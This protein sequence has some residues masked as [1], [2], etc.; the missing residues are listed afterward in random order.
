MKKY[1]MRTSMSTFKRVSYV[2]PSIWITCP[3]N[4]TR[5]HTRRARQATAIVLSES[6]EVVTR[7][8]VDIL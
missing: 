5:K 4:E 7:P 3:Y 1:M 8:T 6:F 2:F